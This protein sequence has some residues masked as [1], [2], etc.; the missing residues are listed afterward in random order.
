[1]R[2]QQARYKEIAIDIVTLIINGEISEGEKISGRSTLSTRYGVS[3]E[4]IRRAIALLKDYGV[5]TSTQKS[6]VRVLSTKKALEYIDTHQDR[7]SFMSLKTQLESIIEER[8]RIDNELMDKTNALINQLTSRRD[9]GIIYPL[10]VVVSNCSH[11]VGKTISESQFW[12]HTSATIIAINRNDKRF[13]SP[14]G[15]WSFD[16]DD[17]IV[18]VGKSNA[19]LKVMDYVSKVK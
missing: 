12:R 5:V 18:F 11:L 4:T 16:S 6:G 9:A 8:Q 17:V 19:Y 14:G 2:K 15:D 7:T 10:E 1:M 3:P 13:L